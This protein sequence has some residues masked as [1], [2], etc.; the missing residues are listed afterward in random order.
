M[1]LFKVNLFIM[2]DRLSPIY[3]SSQRVKQHAQ[4]K[5][6]VARLP[7]VR[8]NVHS[9][10][11]S[12]LLSSVRCQSLP[13]ITT[14][15]PCAPSLVCSLPTGGLFSVRQRRVVALLPPHRGLPA[16]PLPPGSGPAAPQSRPLTVQ[17]LCHR[18]SADR[19]AGTAARQR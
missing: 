5:K 15:H 16:T 3:T 8:S 4:K 18:E 13:S 6:I 17:I 10:H 19:P 14:D 7:C 12:S 11:C 9:G 2:S 1:L